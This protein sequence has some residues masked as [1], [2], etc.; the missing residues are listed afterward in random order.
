MILILGAS[1]YIGSYLF[2]RLKRQGL[3]V[4]GTYFK[5]KRKGMSYF[6]MEDTDIDELGLDAQRIR[7]VIISAA[8]NAKIDESKRYWDK[9]D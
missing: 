4:L 9:E 7:Y 3:G 6:S 1:G 5:N 2:E 8:A